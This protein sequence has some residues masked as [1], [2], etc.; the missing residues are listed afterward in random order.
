MDSSG[1]RRFLWLFLAVLCVRAMA[2]ENSAAE[3]VAISASLSTNL[4]TEDNHIRQF[5]FD[6]DPGTFF[7][8]DRDAARDDHFTLVFE[9]PVL[10][11]SIEIETGRPEGSN[12]LEKGTLDIS[13]DGKT[14]HKLADFKKGALHARVH[15]TQPLAAVQITVT[16]DQKHPLAIREIVIE[17]EP[18]V[19]IFKYPVEFMVDVPDSPEM[20]E[21]AEN[22]ARV[23][24]QAYPMI[25]EELKS[26]GYKP[27]SLVTLSLNDRYKGVAATG[28]THIT[29]SIKYFQNHLSDVGAMV[30]ET[31]HVVQQYHSRNNPGW[32]VEGVADYVRFFMFEPGKLGPINPDRAHYNG[33]YRVTA[34]FLAYLTG[35]YDKDIVPKLNRIMREGQYQE[36]IFKQLTGKTV[37]EL[38]EEWRSTLPR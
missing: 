14:F 24:E 18:T 38:D 11:K 35:K 26:D 12:K 36:E 1:L 23:C 33:S 22:T 13:E 28:G 15:G 6:G 5:A 25:G 34:A 10:V 2:A 4:P 37:Q 27:P 3:V 16:K 8:S 20:K 7:E 19:A 30:H 29:G 9:K 31:V 32:L 21:W 17:S